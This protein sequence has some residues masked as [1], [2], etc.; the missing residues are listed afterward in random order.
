MTGRRCT[1]EPSFVGHDGAPAPERQAHTATQPRP[2][3]L[4]LVE[5]E[6]DLIRVAWDKPHRI[7][8]F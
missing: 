2:E 4:D 7:G 8:P 6:A 3:G 1:H 5:S